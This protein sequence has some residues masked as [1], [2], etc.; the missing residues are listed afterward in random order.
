M[1]KIITVIFALIIVAALPITALAQVPAPG[2]PFSSSFQVQNLDP[3]NT[4]QCSYTFYD[5]AGN[6]AYV[7]GQTSIVPGDSMYVYVPSLP[8]NDGM[9]SGVVMC[10]RKV[11]AVTNFSDND[12]GASHNGIAD[13]APVWYAPGIYD[14]FYNYY[15]NIVV[16]NAT[17][18]PV[19]VTVQIFAPGNPSP[20][21]TRT[22]NN[23]PGY[24]SVSFQQEGMP[25]L[26]NNQFYS[27]KVTGTG[28]VAVVVN[29]YG[30]GGSRT[31]QLYSYNAFQ[32]GSTKAYAPLILNKYYGFDTSLT[33][34]NMGANAANVTVLYTNGVSNNY[35]IQP[36][37]AQAIYTPSVSGLP[38]GN[39]LYGA[40]ITSNN[41]QDLAV[42]VNQSDANGR[43]SSYIGMPAGF[44]EIRAPTV[45]KSFYTYESSITCQNVG[46]AATT[47]TIKY[48]NIANTRTSPSI[49]VGKTFDFYQ[50]NDPLLSGVGLHWKSSAIITATQPIIC[51]VNEDKLPSYRNTP[52][53]FHYS[54]E[55]V[56]P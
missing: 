56:I 6:S 50:G 27:A 3:T 34:Q 43:A 21:A 5:A 46:S 25:E 16:Q 41:G 18:T 42:L 31:Y 9:Y 47:M 8:L 44:T 52:G 1:K 15:S 29:I 55:G 28:D 11:A 26:A 37:A 30:K 48:A 12:S 40:T 53:D 39:V 51:V 24:A 23:V 54:Y 22:S 13:P 32:S 7:S 35:T 38:A 14:N 49:A 19:N 4:A 17:D 36:G 2:G 20:V 45:Y 33:I 10:D